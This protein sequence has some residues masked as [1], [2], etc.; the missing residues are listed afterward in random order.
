MSELMVTIPT[1][2]G[3]ITLPFMQV[4]GLDRCIEMLRFQG[5]QAIWHRANCDCCIIVHEAEAEPC[6]QG[7]VIG[8][9]GEFDWVDAS[10]KSE[11]S[12]GGQE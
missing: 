11:G 8:P 3:D 12:E 5:K 6:Y 4:Q 1:E 7:Y 10:Q 9:D 2:H